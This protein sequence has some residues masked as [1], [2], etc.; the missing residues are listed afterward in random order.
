MG[1][2]GDRHAEDVEGEVPGVE[3]DG[4]D[5]R[6]VAA[7]PAVRLLL[8]VTAQRAVDG[9]VHDREDDDQDHRHQEGPSPEAAGG[10]PAA[11]PRRCGRARRFRLRGLRSVAVRTGS[12]HGPRAMREE[13]SCFPG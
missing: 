5:A 2:L 11:P 7:Q 10:D 1:V 13:G 6:R 8:Q 4:P 12:A 9:H 3:V